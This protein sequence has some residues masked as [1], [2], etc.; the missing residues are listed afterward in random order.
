MY[1]PDLLQG[2]EALG[3]IEER[4]LRRIF[5]SPDG[6]TS[7]YVDDETGDEWELTALHS[8]WQGGGIPQLRC[9]KRGEGE[10]SVG[11]EETHG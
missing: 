8:E 4:Q 9:M 2:N 5:Q 1:P 3:Y 6:W 10:L 11:N 7:H